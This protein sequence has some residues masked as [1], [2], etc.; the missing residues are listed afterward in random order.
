M[1]THA[2]ATKEEF[3]E[4]VLNRVLTKREEEEARAMA[5]LWERVQEIERF[6]GMARLDTRTAR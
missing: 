1:R 3:V 6:V 5:M 4:R 2:M